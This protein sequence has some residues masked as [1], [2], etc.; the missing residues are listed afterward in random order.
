MSVSRSLSSS[1][2]TLLKSGFTP[3]LKSINQFLLFLSKSHKF[4]LI[5]H[6]F[7]QINENK[8]K[9]SSQTHSIFTWALL[10]LNKF[11]E[12]E[13]FM[14]TQME[15]SS[16]VSSFG[17]WDSLIRG[18][19]VNKKDP[20]KGLLVLKDCLRNYGILPSSF[21]FCSLI[22][23]FSYK[24]NMS[25]AIE[26]LG[27]MNDEK[28][29][30]PFDNFV[31][32]S[33]ISGFCK[34]G[35]P[36]FAIGFFDNAVK[37]GALRPN[38]VTY[39]TLVSALCMLGRVSEVCDLVFMM[40]KEELVF[41]VVFYSNWICGYFRVGM[42]MEALQKHGE[43]VKKG[44]YLDMISY[45][46]LI[47]G[48][49]K[50][51]NVEKAVGFLDKMIENGLK[52]NLV[53]YTSIVMGFC[54]KGKMDEAFAVFKM[55]ENIGIEVDEFIYA[56]LIDGVCR[57]R[58]FDHVYQLLQDM[59]LKGISPSIVTYNTLV[60]GLC[61]IG[62]TSEAD[63]VS[64]GI[65]GDT[66]TYSTLL[67]GY[68]EEE[69]IA[70]I[71]EIKRRSEEAGVCM[72]IVMCNILIKALFM[73]GAFED[74]YALYKGMNDM[75]L[76]ADS[77][78]YCTLIDGYCKAGQID[79]ALEMFDEVRRTL[80]SS[81]A[82]YNS[83]INGLCKNGMVDVAKEVFMELNEKGLIF[84]VGIYMTLIKAIFKAERAEGVLNLI[85][86]IENLGLDKYAVICNE[87]ISLLCK[88][89][90]ALD[91]SEVYM[92]L[93]K[94]HLHVTCKS[95]YS[96]LKGLIND[97]KIWL[98]Q[99]LMGSFIREYGLAEPRV[100]KILL[101]YLCL[102][103]INSAL[104]FLNKMKENDPTVTFP[105]CAL[106]VLTKTGRFLAAY[107]L[108]MG[109]TE[110][111]PVMD[112]VDYSI[113]VDGLCKRG[114]PVMALDLCAFAEKK[115]ITFNTITY[116]SII[117]GL[118]H[119]GCLVEAF[120]IFDSLERI[121]LNPSEITYATLIDNLCKEGYFLDAKQLLEKMLLDGYKGNTRIYN[122]FIHGYCKFGQLEEALK[123][124]DDMEINYL[125]PDEFTL[126][127]AI[128]G[129]FQKGDM[130]GALRFYFEYKGKGISPDF[131]GFLH[132]IRGLCAKGR[133]EEARNILRE[134]LQ[135]QSVKE[136]INTVNTEVET[137]SVE[138]ILVMLCEQGSIKE[139]VTVL[140]EV[141]S[142]FFPV[143]KWFGPY[144]ESQELPQLSELNGFSTG[145]SSIVSSLKRTDLD[146][147]SVDKADNMVEN[148]GDMKRMS[149]CNYFDSYYSIIAPLCLKG[150]LQKANILAK[151]M[152]ASFEGDC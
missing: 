151:E 66:V 120:R 55:V 110:N 121:K 124:L 109:A 47:D 42:L 91:A 76:V 86:R 149:K 97:G 38:I 101:H 70:G 103:D 108:V 84:E 45:N 148:P 46:V 21:T 9:C 100:S 48:F 33:I 127:S 58:D 72:D 132:L 12:A 8:I 119:Q 139:A 10:K 69:N 83:I 122:S 50:E 67:N 61:K 134:M 14:K 18:L 133:M 105:V 135:S 24:G 102:K 63:K 147:A 131:L 128:Y 115:G 92:V 140:N 15:E 29:K 49:A 60:N 74:V 13:H 17:T 146:L 20:E 82:C 117:N 52:P 78:T 80:A 143:R 77:V 95:Y 44:I 81:V 51:G 94:N 142:M 141:S 57:K 56:V 137:E 35:K 19:C 106:K 71:L 32:S 150:E 144:N 79:E 104:N 129:F 25:G 112:V 41:D 99:L 62:R 30:Y 118:C 26:V 87:A 31:C 93:R 152:L 111:L 5:T 130:E 85:Y 125:D 136:L 22:H 90:C 138:S 4:N 6:C 2:Q 3:T 40:E 34:I 88:Q 89:N 37:V 28:V 123:I 126:S 65:Q 27:L 1:I 116:N 39:T 75:D 59:E 53:T 107:E 114:Y 23:S 73:V 54:R 96:I 145:S 64:K 113:I 68:T 36:E 43:M 98:S 7:S 11:E 16:Q